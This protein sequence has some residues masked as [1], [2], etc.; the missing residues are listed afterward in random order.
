MKTTYRRLIKILSCSLAIVAVLLCSVCMPVMA[1]SWT[2]LI[3]AEHIA[4]T[5]YEG[6]Y[7]CV[8]YEFGTVPLVQANNQ[9]Y[10]SNSVTVDITSSSCSFRAFPLG[11]LWTG[12]PPL[13]NS[14]SG[15]I[16]IDA[17][18]FRPNAALSVSSQ[19][20][21]ELDIDYLTTGEYLTETFSVET[22]W[23]F[24][25]YRAD[26]TY[27]SSIETE[28]IIHPL[29]LQN[30]PGSPNYVLE[31]PFTMNL[32]FSGFSEDVKYLVP[33]CYVVYRI[34]TDNAYIS[35]NTLKFTFDDF[36]VTTR[37]DMLLQESLTMQAIDDQLGELNDKA[38]T[39]ING[40]DHMQDAADDLLED[41]QD[42]DEQLDNALAELE[43][44]EDISDQLFEDQYT[45]FYGVLNH[46]EGFLIKAPW[47]DMTNLIG[48][49]MEFSPIVTVLTMLVA[50]IN[51]SILFFGR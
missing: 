45:D 8:T 21:F 44:L 37:T 43:D 47:I 31:L 50:F 17:S 14:A 32:A 4:N 9:G 25:G 16:A 10:H 18:D 38:D 27:C 28:T 34:G 46:I 30:V 7:R 49:I 33:L 22:R 5:H 23:L 11:A 39:I 12:G 35:V 51:I 20:N 26:G 1:A 3:P 6:N 2:T 19:A 40:S 36:S 48:P 24:V 41:Q 13:S 29:E 15:S 42:L